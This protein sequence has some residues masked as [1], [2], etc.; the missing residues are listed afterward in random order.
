MD[1]TVNLMA[2]TL[3]VQVRRVSTCVQAIAS[4][5]F[6]QTIETEC[7][8]EILK[9]NNIMNNATSVVYLVVSGVI[10]L[11]NEVA[12]GGIL[13]GKLDDEITGGEWQA[14]AKAINAMAL[15]KCFLKS[16]SV[17]HACTFSLSGA[18]LENLLNH[19]FHPFANFCF[20]AQNANRMGHQRCK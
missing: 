14:M 20:S 5:D 6:D 4:G 1:I 18:C 11:A 12:K 15:G 17:L 7:E 3:T 8:G 13:G 16:C 9:L 10:K 19:A 2:R